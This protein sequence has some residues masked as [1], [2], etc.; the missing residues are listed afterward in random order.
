MLVTLTECLYN[1]FE[2]SVILWFISMYFNLKDNYDRI[3]K[4]S[5]IFI[6]ILGLVSIMSAINMHWIATILLSSLILGIII[7]F[8]YDG[9]RIEHFIIAI[10]NYI[11]LA[12]ADVFAFTLI[13]HLLGVNYSQLVNNSDLMRFLAVISSKLTNIILL[14]IIIFFKRKYMLVLSVKEFISIVC[15][16][17]ISIIQI[18]IIRNVIYRTGYHYKAFLI[19]IICSLLI[20]ISQY[21]IIIY[22]SQKNIDEKS[23]VLMKKQIEYQEEMLIDLEQKYDETTKIRHDIKNHILSALEMANQA[24]YS[25]L[26]NYLSELL[27][28]KI[29]TITNY[30]PTNRKI[31]GAVLNSKLSKAKKANINMNC[32]IF[33]ELENVN[34][35]DV[36]ILLANLLDNAIEACQKN[37]GQSEIKVKMWSEAGYYFISLSNTVELD[38]LKNNP[39]LVTSK[40]E[41]NLHGVGLKSVRDIV[42]KYDGIINF[43]QKRNEFFVYISLGRDSLNFK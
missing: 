39:N 7:D 40:G 3:K 30:I 14:S 9:S 11:V 28:E 37:K 21:Y 23:I 2:A 12:L 17:A 35:I 15:T 34:D 10:A 38:V 4:Y 18:S 8:F 29:N 36:G 26:K 1:I 33:S 19:L 5:L 42:K 25:E 16:L 31:I 41:K 27:D 32:C 20:I 43:T 13:G 6:I 22:I 24:N